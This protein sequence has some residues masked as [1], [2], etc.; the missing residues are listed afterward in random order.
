M[1][2][3]IKQLPNISPLVYDYF[4][5]YNRVS[6]FYNGNFRN[7]PEF[8]NQIKRAQSR[9][10]PRDELIAILKKQNRF[11]GCGPQTLENINKLIEN[12]TCG[13]VTGQQVGLFSGPLYTIYKAL[14]VIKLTEYLNNNCDGEFVP[15]FWMASDDHDYVEI[16]HIYLLNKNNHIETIEVSGP[17]SDK[18]IPASKITLPSEIENCFHQLENA[19]HHSEFKQEMVSIL[20]DSYRSGRSFPE[21]FAVLMTQL[22]KSYG[23]IFVDASHP[24]IK[25]LGKNVFYTEIAENSPS[26]NSVLKTSQ[27][28]NNKYHSQ[29]Q[30]HK[31][32]LNLFIG[33]NKRQTIQLADGDFI[34]KSTQQSYKRDELL[35]LLEQKAELF[36]PNVILRPIYQDALL[37]TV[38]YVG[39][40][41]EIAYFS[42]LKGVYESFGLSMPIIY[43]R[44]TL[45]IVEKK[46][47]RVL[48]SYHLKIQ[49]LWRN[50]DGL[51]NE[52]IKKQIPGSID[53][54]IN[55][56]KSHLDQDFQSI[57]KEMIAFDP[58][59]ENPVNVTMG[60]MTQQVQYLEKKILQASKKKN[61]IVIQQFHKMKNNLYPNNILQERAFNIVPYLIKYGAGLIDKL[62]ST[63]DI[64]N[65]DHQIINL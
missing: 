56:I 3:P 63:I 51:I 36:S 47:E 6:E 19:T 25:T 22:F 46:I 59:L 30:L 33:E 17:S 49:E 13:V 64:N 29:I 48:K 4:Y 26:T 1:V 21:A 18:K 50:G 9:I 43:P 40:P 65:H 12:Q 61:E 15:F 42:Q 35:A 20:C 53:K 2:I 23:L 58:T 8:Q 41:G 60:K 37:P 38:A 28:L 52:M 16:N 14:T 7:I 5:N 27:K 55:L 57:K 44:K 10:L 32:I 62:Y 24:A 31:G 11:Y 45:T 34:N 39:G 54:V